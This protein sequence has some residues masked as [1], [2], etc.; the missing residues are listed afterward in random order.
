MRQRDQTDCGPTCLAYLCRRLGR[1]ESVARLRQ[2]AGTDR[3]GTTALGLIQAARRVGFE[4]EGIKGSAAEAVGL[5]LPFIAH[6]ILPTGHAHFVV[7]DRVV[8]DGFVVM[9]PAVG[10]VARWSRERFVVACSGVFLRLAAPLTAAAIR[11]ERAV[12]ASRSA[13]SPW[14]RLARVLW[15][16]RRLV[17]AT[18]LGAVVATVLSLALP[19]YVKQ[20]VDAVVPRNDR[21]LLAVLGLA[22]VLFVGVR[23]ALGWIQG[24]WTLRLGQRLDAHLLLGYHRHLLTL[25]ATFHESMRVGD[26]LSRAGDAIKVR[27]F[28]STTLV[29]MALHPLLLVGALGA[30]FLMHPMLGFVAAAL[31]AVQATLA[32]WVSR[33]SRER[34]RELLHAGSEWQAH[35]AESWSNHTTVRA[36]RWEAREKSRAERQLVRLLG[37]GRGVVITGLWTGVVGQGSAQL[38]TVGTLWVGAALVL[39][40]QLTLGELM[41][42][43]ALSGYV[44]GPAAALL[45]L[46]GSVQEAVAATERFFEVM[47]LE[48]DAPV[49]SRSGGDPV[50]SEVR[51]EQVSLQPAGRLPILR[52]LS[53]TFPS[54]CWTT[55]AGASGGGK[56]SVLALVQGTV[57]PSAGQVTLG[58]RDLA[59]L[60]PAALRE[61]LSVLPQRVELFSGTILDNLTG[62]D[63]GPDAARLAAACRDAGVLEWIEALPQGF[64]TV[65]LEAGATLSGGQRQRLAL[66]RALYRPCH[67]LVLDEPTS[68]LDAH[69]EREIVAALRRRVDAGLTLIVASHAPTLLA[70]ADRVLHLQDGRCVREDNFRAPPSSPVALPEDWRESTTSP[71]SPV[72]PARASPHG[73]LVALGSSVE[74]LTAEGADEGGAVGG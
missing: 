33:V 58:G 28:L 64:G 63:G 59:S 15:P 66:A 60:E 70:A 51:F 6:V 24:V 10:E 68:A 50:G 29:G 62:G 21:W 30:L 20:V 41:G 53:V 7:V 35:L 27:T 17:F 57:R 74:R 5:P 2:W 73:P 26:L 61:V 12:R 36:L 67:V 18:G 45:T 56:S 1:P 44:A 23:Q 25:P 22:M 54:G 46:S 13:P 14:M 3:G 72:A 37:A 49:G 19:L 38:Y 71:S 42:A 52:D 65:L 16:H 11:G 40:D 47:D 48:G 31:L 34:Q 9:D 39:Q 69:A 32:P 8:A 43:Y 55:L 4:L